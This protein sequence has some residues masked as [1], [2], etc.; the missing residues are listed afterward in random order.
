MKRLI[1]LLLVSILV[2]TGCSQQESQPVAAQPET[3][4]DRP[5]APSFALPAATPSPVQGKPDDVLVEVNGK[6][7]TR[8]EAEELAGYRMASVRSQVR[9]EQMA[10]VK[11][12]FVGQILDQFVVRTLLIEEAD[13][14]EIK[15]T[16]EDRKLAK[17]KMAPRM[18]KGMTVDEYMKTSA[19]GE[20]RMKEELEVGIRIEKLVALVATNVVVSDA[21]VDAFIDQNKAR[22]ERVKASHILVGVD[23]KAD[24]A[25]K[26]EKK[27]AAE[28]I[29][30]KLL[31][32]A[33]FAALAKEHSTCSSKD[34]G[35]DL[36]PHFT[37]GRMVK[38][39]EEAAFSQKVGEIGPIVETKFGYHIVKVTDRPEIPRDRVKQHLEMQKKNK[40][41]GVLIEDL[42]TKSTINYLMPKGQPGGLPPAFRKIEKPGAGKPAQSQ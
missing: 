36:G 6:K 4:A 7:L 29:R 41:M 13:R 3:S 28:E 34:K 20:E 9:P 32:G 39:F 17:E 2:T 22:L 40:A 26:A 37:R 24:D 23:P 35:G 11:Q 25:A 10:T 38:E 5:D 27:K 18:P 15:V 12:N 8:A 42:R 31:D 21:E 16:E 19:M 14:R 1:P 30:K 33:D